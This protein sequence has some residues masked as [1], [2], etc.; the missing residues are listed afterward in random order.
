M[1]WDRAIGDE[2]YEAGHQG[3]HAAAVAQ[4]AGELQEAIDTG[5]VNLGCTQFQVVSRELLAM[6]EPDEPDEPTRYVVGWPALLDYRGEGVYYAPDY[7]VFVADEDDHVVMRKF[8]AWSHKLIEYGARLRV[9]HVM[10]DKA[11]FQR[12]YGV[13][14]N[15]EV[16]MRKFIDGEADLDALGLV[17]LTDMEVAHR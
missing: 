17:R 10:F 5:G 13:A 11:E 6:A 1:A 9:E 12:R 2:D 14:G 15:V 8:L 3:D 16:A 7:S 4:L